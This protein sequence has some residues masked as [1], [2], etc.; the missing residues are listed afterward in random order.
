[1]D[2]DDDASFA[3][4]DEL[5]GAP[6][7]RNLSSAFT[8]DLDY[9]DEGATHM[10]E[11]SKLA[12]KDPEFYKYLQEHDHD[13]L[14]FDVDD[15]DDVEDADDNVGEPDATQLPTLTKN[16]LRTWQ[17]SLLEVGKPT[18]VVGLEQSH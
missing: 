7:G 12:E 2:D 18:T 9:V 3:S 13:L 10:L 8:Q 17:K 4:V 6:V 16:I 5:D 14:E 1:M 15:D 11:L